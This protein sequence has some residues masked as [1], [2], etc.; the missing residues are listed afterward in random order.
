MADRKDLPKWLQYYHQQLDI[1]NQSQ[2]K[3]FRELIKNYSEVMSRCSSLEEQ[4]HSA[5]REKLLTKSFQYF[6]VP[7][8]YLID[9]RLK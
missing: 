1:R 3:A 5:E 4:L 7:K 9:N 8:A 6:V 2:S